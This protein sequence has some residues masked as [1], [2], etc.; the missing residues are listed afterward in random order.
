MLEKK[1]SS[2]GIK[3]IYGK[4]WEVQYNKMIRKIPGGHHTKKLEENIANT[5]IDSKKKT[6]VF[7]GH[8][9]HG[10]SVRSLCH[11]GQILKAD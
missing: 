2:L 7:K 1:T 4:G 9:P 6:D 3:E 8:F 5:D 11:F 10:C